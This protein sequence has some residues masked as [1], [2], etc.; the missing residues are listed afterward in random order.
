MANTN[1]A[2]ILVIGATGFLGM[3][4]CRLL[5]ASNRKVKGLIRTGSDPDKVKALQDMRVE[6]ITG[7][8]KD[9]ASLDIAMKGI[10][11]VIST[12]TSTISRQEGD[13]IETVDGTGQLNVVEAAKKAGVK[14][15]VFISFHS[16]P[17]EFPLQT[18]KRN[19]E[20]AL[21]ESKMAFTIL[22]PTM[23]MEMWLSPIIGFNYPESKA[24][25]YGD[26]KNKL[27]WVSL[28]DVAA[29]AVASLDNPAAI[30]KIFEIGGP[31]PLSPLEVV[32]IFEQCSGNTFTVEHV[33]VEALLAQK[34]NA[35]DSLSQSFTSLM[36]AYAE[37][38]VIP[39]EETLRVLPVQLKS[40]KEYAASVSK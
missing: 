2:S 9:R 8:M 20:L 33:P 27:C 21:I 32:D 13:S 30:N 15:F 38:K 19:V 6:T 10:A 23:F 16:M 12:A 31:E 4:I 37:E 39:M 18:A 26:G 5:T 28:Q 29:L 1:D 17:Q 7:D 40:V 14:H 36:I 24:T 34:N 22:Q 35:P 3:E 25:I 11:T